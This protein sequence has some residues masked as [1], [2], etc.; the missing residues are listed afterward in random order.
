MCTSFSQILYY[1]SKTQSLISLGRSQSFLV[2]KSP[3]KCY[4]L[5]SCVSFKA[6]SFP[7]TD[8]RYLLCGEVCPAPSLSPSLVCWE[9][10]KGWD[11]DCCLTSPILL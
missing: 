11:R 4:I 3:V 6:L 2:L 8:S 5:K 7:T 10:K 1:V 9:P